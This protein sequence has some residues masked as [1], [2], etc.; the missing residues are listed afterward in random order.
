MT[1]GKGGGRHLFLVV[2][3]DAPV[4]LT[5]QIAGA[6]RDK[7]D[8]GVLQ[9][10]DRLPSSRG[11]AR[12][13]GV[14]RNTVVAA[15]LRLQAEGYVEARPGGSVRVAI[16][17]VG[18]PRL[19]PLPAPSQ[20]IAS[21][22]RAAP[23][24]DPLPRMLAGRPPLVRVGSVPR[25]FRPSVPAMDLFPVE[26]WGRL[27]S[28]TWRRASL[29]MMGYG[30]PMGYRPLRESVVRHLRA[31]RGIECEVDQVMI[32]QGS[33]Q[34]LDFAARVLI[35]PGDLAW[36]EDPGFL[37][38]RGTLIAA[39]ARIQAVPVDAEGMTVPR[40]P[41]ARAA[42][43]TPARQ[44][45]LGVQ[46]SL[47]RR[48]QLLATAAATG[49]AVIEDDYDAA[50]SFADEP[51]PP[52]AAIDRD[53]LVLHA[54]T[55]SKLLYPALRLGYLLVPDTLVDTVSALRQASDFHPPIIEQ[56]TLDG[57]IREGHLDRHLRRMRTCYHERYRLL[58]ERIRAE[59]AGLLELQVA[60][61]G[62][63]V[64]AWLPHGTCDR[65]C[66][67][68]AAEAGVDVLPISSMTIERRLRAGLLLG[69][70]GLRDD[71]IAA[72]VTALVAA[73]GRRPL[74]RLA[75]EGRA[76]AHGSLVPTRGSA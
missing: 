14:A 73:L 18:A 55:F 47:A 54:G 30:D 5:E 6:L 15:Y 49:M 2:R 19:V 70:G 75:E 3:R 4:P 50:F 13:V 34:A 51:L 11:L 66:A 43:V 22:L 57:F 12:E 36:V 56:A 25:A 23:H 31:A 76:A 20:R 37:W 58:A 24:L 1:L 16:R 40:L 17:E 44:L 27:L 21:P 46:M 28:R 48:R 10:G 45:P 53:G 35:T 52:L 29:Q 8:R 7:I 61:G 64:V 39:G 59:A 68:L 71:E 62:M 33:L 60:T 72:G 42:L 41:P 69:F 74:P 65:A 63:N 32:T 9:A 38:G 67:R 26:L